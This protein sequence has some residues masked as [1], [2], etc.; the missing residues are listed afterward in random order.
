M[1][2]KAASVRPTLRLATG[3]VKGQ[4]RVSVVLLDG[5]VMH[6]PWGRRDFIAKLQRRPV[7]SA[8]PEAELWFGAHQNGASPAYGLDGCA[9]L[10]DVIA[11]DPHVWLGTE[12]VARYGEQLPFLLKVLAV[13]EPLSLQ[14]HP[15]ETLV[16]AL[17]ADGDPDGILADHH[18]KPE[19]VVA[20]GELH[21][22]CGFLEA[23]EASQVVDEIIAVTGDDAWL[24][25]QQQIESAGVAAAVAALIVADEA[26]V[27]A[28]LGALGVACDKTF[29]AAHA[30]AIGEL[31]ARYPNDRSVAI[32]VLMRLVVLAD[33]EALFIPPGVLHCY[34]A[35]AG[36]E[37][38]ASSDNVL[39][40]GLTQKPCHP[41]IANRQ[42][43]AT[44]QHATLVGG[45]RDGNTC[46]Y[47]V[48]TPW[49]ALSRLTVTQQGVT[50]PTPTYGPQ[51][52]LVI[53]GDVTVSEA[54]GSEHTVR[55]GAGMFVAAGTRGVTLQGDADVFVATLGA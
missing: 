29:A 19:M 6:Y 40:L 16:A 37:V 34:L 18:P 15:D 28:L 17:A 55:S 46:T 23:H 31:L 42:L 25:V 50:M 26:H 7:P 9:T 10:A 43:A 33:G 30:P 1:G 8:E 2:R 13:N 14:L 53:G 39:R 51:I 11:N 32:A 27:S 3:K 5:V 12:I 4:F 47:L 22:M 48:D 52:A 49:F 35:G 20:V 21:A 44:R 41:A 45:E 54:N 36:V 24:W 38:M